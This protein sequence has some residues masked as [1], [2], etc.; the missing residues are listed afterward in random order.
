MSV[1]G[2][3]V[4]LILGLVNFLLLL[5]QLATGLRWVKV[6]PGVHRRAGF[7]LIGSGVLH[8]GLALLGDLL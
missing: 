4:V 7:G 8:G 6:P 3:S 1:G 5:F 2:V